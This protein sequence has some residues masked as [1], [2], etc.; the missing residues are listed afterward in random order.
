MRNKLHAKYTSSKQ[1]KKMRRKE[2]SANQHDEVEAFLKENNLDV[3]E[4]IRNLSV[5]AATE[6]KSG[7]IVTFATS[8]ETI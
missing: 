2:V 1:Y 3:T 8:C 5:S 7:V 4:R 6:G